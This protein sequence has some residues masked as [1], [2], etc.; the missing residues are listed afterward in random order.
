MRINVW[1]YLKEYEQEKEE[2][3]TA[4]EQVFR[5]GQLILGENVRQ[6]EQ[7]FAAYCE[8]QHGV[9]VDNG[10]N[11]IMLGLLALG[12][13][14]GD[15]VITVANTAVPTVSAIVSAGGVPRFVDIDPATYLMDTSLLEAAIT[16]KSRCILPVHLFGQCVDMTAVSVIA[17]QH[18]LL[19]LEDCA[20]AHGARF[21]G[22]VAGSMAQAAAFSFYPTK[23]L[24]TYGD[25]GMVITNDEGVV[26]K[27]RRLRFY[28]MENTYYAEEH[29]Y[30]SRLDELHAA[31]LRRKLSH[32][33]S[34]LARRREL[35]NR[36][37][38][39]L[40][41]TGL[42]LPKVSLQNDHAYYLYV[43]RHPRRDEIVAQLKEYDIFVNISYPWPIHT[44]RGYKSL[45]YK[46]GDLPETEA[47]A[48]EIF[49]LP[50]YP[51]LTDAEQDRVC[52]ALQTIMEKLV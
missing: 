3:H 14:P 24:G 20:Q 19:T 12:L 16:P 42:L 45:G 8:V 33:N 2:I 41:D 52:V 50:M 7:A 15:E 46:S 48:T 13:Q 37:D 25:G 32:L 34:Y 51:T 6:F 31:I 23:I 44:M 28:G 29:G 40:A 10:T 11:A 27:L 26:H 36:Y 35:A 1:D 18:N 43:V 5:S 38:T 49:S 39:E 17:R 4:I 22:K 9:G 47:A 21:Q 30:N